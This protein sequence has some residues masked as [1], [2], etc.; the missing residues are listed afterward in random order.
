MTIRV[1]IFVSRE[2]AQML[3]IYHQSI[4]K[5]AD[6]AQRIYLRPG[7]ALVVDNYRSLR[8]EGS[9]GGQCR[10]MVF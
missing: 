7:D 3:E 5:A 2:D 10:S 9:E 8:S 1:R 4:Q 6:A